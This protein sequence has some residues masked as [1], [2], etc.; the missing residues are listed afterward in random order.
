MFLLLSTG[1][2]WYGYAKIITSGS[3]SRQVF[4]KFP[5]S[6]MESAMKDPGLT[7]FHMPEWKSNRRTTLLEV[8]DL[9]RRSLLCRTRSYSPDRAIF[10]VLR[11]RLLPSAHLQLFFPFTSLK[12][13]EK[14]HVGPR[15]LHWKK[16][17]S[18]QARA[19]A[20]V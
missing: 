18:P 17:Y 16:D 8:L 7:A 14:I 1:I 5:K 4:F 12:L 19:T 11:P 9:C 6:K 10:C 3:A 2:L 20:G 15:C 13:G